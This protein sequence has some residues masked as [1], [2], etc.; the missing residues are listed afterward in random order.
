[1]KIHMILKS[2]IFNKVVYSHTME[3]HRHFTFESM[4][5]ILLTDWLSTLGPFIDNERGCYTCIGNKV[6]WTH[7]EYSWLDLRSF[8]QALIE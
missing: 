5:L 7:L 2:H 1:M 3:C 6:Y 8:V 4:L